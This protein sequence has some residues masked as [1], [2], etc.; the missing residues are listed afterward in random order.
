MNL[1]LNLE[2]KVGHSNWRPKSSA[3]SAVRRHLECEDERRWTV[4]GAERETGQG[5]GGGRS[6]RHFCRC[7]ETDGDLHNGTLN[8]IRPNARTPAPKS[9]RINTLTPSLER[10]ASSCGRICES[11]S[12]KNLPGNGRIDRH[13]KVRA[14]FSSEFRLKYVPNL[15]VAFS[16]DVL[17][18]FHST[19]P[20]EGQLSLDELYLIVRDC[21]SQ[22]PTRET[23]E[24]PTKF[25][26]GGADRSI[27]GSGSRGIQDGALVRLAS[28]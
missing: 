8:K 12:L 9:R 7:R 1:D 21:G 16:V 19:L 11:L 17:G 23:T 20:P 25:Y 24:G 28:W 4:V 15:A 27:E 13:H 14:H 22:G 10:L 2:L 18:L 6:G 5:W 26:Q 3:P